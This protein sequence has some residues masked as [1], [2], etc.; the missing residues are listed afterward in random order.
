MGIAV[1]AYSPLPQNEVVKKTPGKRFGRNRDQAG[2]VVQ[3][4]ASTVIYDRRRNGL[5]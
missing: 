3:L 5:I 2:C 1:T 4:Q